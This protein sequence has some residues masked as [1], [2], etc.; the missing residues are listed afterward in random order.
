VS[1]ATKLL[2]LD[3][4][5]NELTGIG[6]ANELNFLNSLTN[7]SSLQVLGLDDDDFG[8]VL[9]NSIANLS[10]QLRTLTLR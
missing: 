1:N 9:P 10:S 8:A 4:S 6:K 2:L 3:V 5:Q 7:C